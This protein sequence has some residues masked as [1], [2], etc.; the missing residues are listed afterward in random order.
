MNQS[1]LVMVER[2][3]GKVPILTSRDL[4]PTLIHLFKTG[5][6]SYFDSKDITKD[7]QV[8]KILGGIEDS[9]IQDWI[10]ADC[11]HFVTLLL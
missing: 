9:C 5:C 7:K 1:K 6:L 4:N 11:D 10:A 2:A 3:S 8:Q